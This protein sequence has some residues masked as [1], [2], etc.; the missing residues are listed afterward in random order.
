MFNQIRNNSEPTYTE[1]LIRAKAEVAKANA[2]A[3]RCQ[4]EGQGPNLPPLEAP[5]H[6]IA[7]G[8][9][10]KSLLLLLVSASLSFP[11]SCYPNLAQCIKIPIEN[12]ENLVSK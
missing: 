3:P 1:C 11:N 6:G 2:K 5:P 8:D 9:Y 10:L 4:T 7:L 12:N